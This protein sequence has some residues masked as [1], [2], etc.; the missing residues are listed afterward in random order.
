MDKPVDDAMSSGRGDNNKIHLSTGSWFAQSEILQR[1]L[2]KVALDLTQ[3]FPADI[4]HI[5]RPHCRKLACERINLG[6]LL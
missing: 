2:R 3:P 6:I 5:N 4:R 1:S